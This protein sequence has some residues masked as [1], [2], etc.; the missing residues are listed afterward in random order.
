M[1]QSS[2]VP[3]AARLWLL[4]AL[5]LGSL[6]ASVRSAEPQLSFRAA[7]ATS[8]EFDTGSLRG[9]I[10]L[11]GKSQ[12]ISSL[13]HAASGAE[14]AAKPGL[15]SFYRIFSAGQ[16]F[17]HAARDWP[18]SHRI[19]D[20]GALLVEFAPAEEYPFQLAACFRWVA[21]DTLD[22]ETTVR[23]KTVLPGFE[24]FLSSYLPR[25]YDGL[26]YGKPNRYA[27]QEPP[28]FI[29]ADW[30]ELTDGNYLIF[31]RQPSDLL[32]IYDGRWEIPPNPVTWTFAR[33]FEAPAGIRRS[34]AT[35]LTVAFFSR[36]ADCFA[37][38]MP[39]NKE[40]ADGVAGHGSLYFCLFGRDLAAGETATARCRMI[41]GKDLT[42]EAV[43]GRYAEFAARP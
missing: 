5:L 9:S 33:Y 42:D 1:I 27:K 22:L 38:A 39:Y 25:G 36:P 31:P 3:E 13:V 17:G 23:A 10:R 43:L 20:T 28:K 30:S 26:I 21:A 24:V 8:V 16:R 32:L 6:P 18:V 37:V 4:P 41:V 2:L 19:L 35:G 15:L 11:D 7:S 29:R 40:P 34:S 14:L 12:G